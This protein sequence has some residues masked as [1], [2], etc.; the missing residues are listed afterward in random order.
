V[1]LL[2]ID[3]RGTRLLFVPLSALPVESALTGADNVLF[4]TDHDG[5][6]IEFTCQ[7]PT[8][9]RIADTDAYAVHVPDYIVRLQRRN[10]YR[11]PAPAIECTLEAEGAHGDVVRPRV[12]DVSAGGI[13][14]EMPASEPPLSR[15]AIYTCSMFL[16]ALGNVWAH[17]KIVSV[18]ETSPARRY[19]CQFLD[20]SAPSEVLLQRY[21]LEEQ[22]TRRRIRGD[23]GT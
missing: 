1:R 22:R 17:L 13:D 8:Q 23:T 2:E 11:L 7:H 10:A 19:G 9:V 4:T 6:P 18:F 12:L 3:R 16:P 20:L 5:V 15:D 21:I 14:I